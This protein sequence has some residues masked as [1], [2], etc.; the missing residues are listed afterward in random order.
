MSLDTEGRLAHQT[1]HVQLERALREAHNR[2]DAAFFAVGWIRN[3]VGDVLRRGSRKGSAACGLSPTPKA[4]SAATSLRRPGSSSHGGQPSLISP[5][6]GSTAATGH[7]SGLA[8]LVPAALV[9]TRALNSWTR[10]P[11]FIS[12]ATFVCSAAAREPNNPLLFVE[13]MGF[14][15]EVGSKG[16]SLKR[17]PIAARRPIGLLFRLEPAAT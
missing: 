1:G 17:R 8:A 2:L 11:L 10:A 15:G 13:T 12:A 6:W 9:S 14:G 4:R 5:T 7:A 3:D 16:S